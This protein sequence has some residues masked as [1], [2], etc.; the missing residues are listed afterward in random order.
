MRTAIRQDAITAL[1]NID[2]LHVYPSHIYPTETYPAAFVFSNREDNEPDG[3]DGS[4]RE[5]SINIHVKVAGDKNEIDS[6]MDGLTEQIET[7]IAFLPHESTLDEIEFDHL[8][9]DQ[10]I[11]CAD[12]S[13]VFGY[14]KEI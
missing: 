9:G 14:F 10:A 7:E 4:R 13:F 2:G 12:M 3:M 6:I 5:Y 11:G 1:R 8:E